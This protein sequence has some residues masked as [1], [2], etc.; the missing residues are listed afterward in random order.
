MISYAD[1]VEAC[2]RWIDRVAATIVAGRE[3]LR[4][5]P[6]VQLAEQQD[7]TFRAARDL[8]KGISGFA[9]PADSSRRRA[10]RYRRRGCGKTR[11]NSLARRES[12]AR[13]AT[14]SFHIPATRIAAPRFGFSR[15]DCSLSDRPA[16]AVERGEAAFG[17]HP[18]MDHRQRSDRSDNRRDGA[19]ADRAFHQ[20]GHGTRRRYRHPLGRPAAAEPESRRHQD[21]R[22]KGGTGRRCAPPPAHL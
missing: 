13:L 8:A 11:R 4:T 17:W 9:R 22:A 3:S 19:D 18:A 7:G 2:S 16:D 20:R 10:R 14:Q 21:M 6:H 5:R 15:R 1:I 12:R